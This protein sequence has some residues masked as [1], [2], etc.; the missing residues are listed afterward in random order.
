M[1]RGIKLHR[2]QQAFRRSEA[3]Y[4]GFVG[5]RGAGKTWIGSYDLLRRAQN[6]RTYLVASPTS[7][8]LNDTTYPTFTGMA[9]DLGLFAS[10]RKTPYPTVQ[11][12]TG[13]T[14]RFRTAEDPEKLR[15]PN[16]S[17]VWLDEASLMEEQAFKIAIACLREGGQQGWLSATFTPKGRLHWTYEVFGK[18]GPGV[19]LFRAPTKANP[20]NPPEFARQLATQYHGLLARQE[21]GGEFTDIE[22]AEWPSEFFDGPGFWFTDWPAHLDIKVMALDPSKG[23]DA[24]TSDYQALVMYGRDHQG[25]EWIEADMG[26]RP[27]TAARAP[28]GT[29]L[30]DGMVEHAVEVYE[31]FRPEALAVE[32]NQF[33]Q[34]LLVPFRLEAQRRKLDIRFVEL[35][36]RVKKEVRIRRLGEPLSQRRLHF[37][38]TPDT[39]L[40]VDQMRVFPEGE[41][42]DGP[43]ALEMARRSAI[44]L[45][46]GK[47]RGR[48]TIW[49]T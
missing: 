4:R 7:I 36:N 34:L 14:I 2:V 48:P 23:A 47:S 12:T 26:K 9:R 37:R 24:R 22:G 27:M 29:A 18:G 31:S 19:D 3:L 40:L 44:E 17:G 38:A 49:R 43:D 41:N 28:D 35:D 16:L 1:T 20:F 6:G 8:L 30:T 11:L 21:L 46:N 32:T 13:A 39:R 33:Q 5:G 42:D 15:G 25:G 10:E 45:F